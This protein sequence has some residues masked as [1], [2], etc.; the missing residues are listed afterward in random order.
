MNPYQEF[1]TLREQSLKANE[2]V[3]G[4]HTLQA[5]ETLLLQ[6]RS[7]L[8][9][10][11]GVLLTQCSPHGKRWGEARRRRAWCWNGCVIS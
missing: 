6:Q 10:L 2:D 9:E 11:Q 3:M 7:C 8:E 1:Y 4:I 5:H